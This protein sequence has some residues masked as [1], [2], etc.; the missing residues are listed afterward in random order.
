M[1]RVLLIDD[2]I[3]MLELLKTKV[4]WADYQCEVTC[5]ASNGEEALQYVQRE[6]PDFVVTDIKMPGM[7]GLSF[8]EH[9][10]HMRD[11]IPIVL[12]SAYENMQTAR[13]AMKYNVTEYL[14]KPLNDFNIQLL[15]SV[16]EQ[17][18]QNKTQ[19]A[20]Y[21][22]LRDPHYRSEIAAHLKQ[23]DVSWFSDFFL[24]FTDCTSTRFQV[25]KEACLCMI[26]L[27]SADHPNEK[28]LIAQHTEQLN[29]CTSKM[30]LVSFTAE[31]YDRELNVSDQAP[32]ST[33]CQAC[34]LNKI[35]TYIDKNFANPDCGS[36]MLAEYFH[37]SADYIGRIF[38]RHMGVTISTYV[39]SKRMT[40]ALELL[41]DPDISV[42]EV[43]IRSGFRNQNY[44]SRTFR[45]KM[46]M[47]PTEYQSQIT[48]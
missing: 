7:D 24:H 28:K 19:Q 9:L 33:D 3:T 32:D 30:Q 6:M 47:T 11:D 23:R 26:E 14:L 10:H 4:P 34:I 16:L 42:N 5:A 38:M 45:K 12:L 44:F 13:I 29:R 31:L 25:L 43:A 22:S 40:Y 20:F 15:C 8:C 37:F 39:A 48:E 2:D 36:A 35:T 18:V 17:W 27:L 21:L 41:H 1:F 46:Q